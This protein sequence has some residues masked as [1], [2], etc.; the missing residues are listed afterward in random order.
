ME[1]EAQIARI[2]VDWVLKFWFDGKFFMGF[3]FENFTE[4]G[5]EKNK[6]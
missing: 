3:E 2:T 5:M 1:K 4:G 6:T